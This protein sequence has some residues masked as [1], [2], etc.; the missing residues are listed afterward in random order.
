MKL[1]LNPELSLKITMIPVPEIFLI[2]IVMNQA[3]IN[4]LKNGNLNSPM[5]NG[6]N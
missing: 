1:I 5:K 6:S 4:N 3:E 2:L